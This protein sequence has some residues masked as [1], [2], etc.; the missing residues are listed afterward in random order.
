V[1]EVGARPAGL[2]FPSCAR[3]P[4]DRPG[5]DRLRHP[6]RHPLP[7]TARRGPR[8]GG[9][10]YG[11]WL[12]VPAPAARPCASRRPARS[13]AGTA[14]RT[15]STSAVGQTLADIPGYEHSGASSASARAAPPRSR[16]R[17]GRRA[18]PEVP[19]RHPRPGRRR[20]VVV[21]AA[22]AGPTAS[23]PSP[24]W[25]TAASCTLPR[26]PSPPGNSATWPGTP[27]PP[28]PAPPR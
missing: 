11:G 20:A 3:S 16:P 19:R 8:P 14:G 13:W 25:L 7:A 5:G 23:T 6:G 21:I 24:P 10:E 15:P 27:P 1:L 17:S 26:P 22:A 4:R 12:L 18:G 9:A 28:T 2:R